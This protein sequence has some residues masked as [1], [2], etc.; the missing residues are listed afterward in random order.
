MKIVRSKGALL[1][2][3]GAWL[4]TA[5]G[6]FL[7]LFGL[8][9]DYILPSSNPG[10]NLPQ[11]LVAAAGAGL[12]LMGW[13]LRRDKFRVWLAQQLGDNLLKAAVI[14][15]ITLLCVEF[16]LVLTGIA[17]YYPTELPQ[18]SKRIVDWWFCDEQ[19]GCRFNPDAAQAACERGELLGRYCVFNSMGY[20][21]SDEFIATDDL[22]QQ[23]R[24]L[25]LG[26]SWTH[27]LNADVGHSYVETIERLL[28]ELEV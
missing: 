27:G 3:L 23:D 13:Q 5:A 17:T 9:L 14:T 16:A 2:S 1:I 8:L 24:V 28:P 4:L 25:V 11:L 12:A 6:L 20:A 26:D 7:A 19:Q 22:M 15:I 10:I 21:D 18:T